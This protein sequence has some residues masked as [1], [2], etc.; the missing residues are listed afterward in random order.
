M[1]DRDEPLAAMTIRIPASLRDRVAEQAKK[2]RR[3]TNA[4]VIFVL[5][6]EFPDPASDGA[7]A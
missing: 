6:R 3:S 4:Q 5:E 1:S 7:S 2:D